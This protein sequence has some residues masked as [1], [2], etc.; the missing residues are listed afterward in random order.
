[1]F[2]FIPLHAAGVYPDGLCCSN[3][4]VSSYVPTL[5]ALLKAQSGWEQP[6]VI[7]TAKILLASV[8]HT[9]CQFAQDLP[10]TVEEIM[11]IQEL[12]CGQKAPLQDETTRVVV[13]HDTTSAALKEHLSGVAILHLAS[14][15]VQDPEDQIGR[16]HV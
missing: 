9:N 14:H 7:D 2:N 5:S 16:A 12:L 6:P 10:G 4:C 15:G 11:T 13:L 8:L 1:M 3:Y